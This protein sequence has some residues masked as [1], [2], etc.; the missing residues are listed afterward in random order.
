MKNFAAPL[1]AEEI[2]KHLKR[3]FGGEIIVLE[4]VRS[5]NTY[6]LDLAK[7]GAGHATVVLAEEQT[8]GRGR[9]ERKFDFRIV[10]PQ[11]RGNWF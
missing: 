2:K 1:K 9:R 6:A 8:G 10:C 5:T 7:D 3:P 11:I 4:S